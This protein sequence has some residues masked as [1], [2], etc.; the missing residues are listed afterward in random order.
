MIDEYEAYSAIQSHAM[1]YYAFQKWMTEQRE[2]IDEELWQRIYDQGY[3][4]GSTQSWE[5]AYV[6]AK[7]ELGV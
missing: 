1:S 5:D 7:E 2:Y 3:G 4:D 6:A